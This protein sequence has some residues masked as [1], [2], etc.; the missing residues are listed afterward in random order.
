MEA[1][2]EYADALI[3][4]PD[5]AACWRMRRERRA[6]ASRNREASSATARASALV[7]PVRLIAEV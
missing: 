1:S 2:A 5:T 3:S 7:V 4:S 6:T